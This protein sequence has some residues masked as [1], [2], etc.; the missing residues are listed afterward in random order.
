MS[1]VPT[2][3]KNLENLLMSSFVT[4]HSKHSLVVKSPMPALKTLKPAS[5]SILQYSIKESPMRHI[6]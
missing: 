6:C 4:I 1:L 2:I 3:I 5:V